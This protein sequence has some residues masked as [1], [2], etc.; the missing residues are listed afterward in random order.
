MQRESMQ[1]CAFRGSEVANAYAR[2]D[3]R[4]DLLFDDIAD[5]AS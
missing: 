5:E 4:D 1:C 2:M 3:I